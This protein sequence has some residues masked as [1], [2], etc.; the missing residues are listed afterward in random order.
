MTKIALG[1]FQDLMRALR[2]PDAIPKWKNM[3]RAEDRQDPSPKMGKADY[4]T[5]IRRIVWTKGS[6]NALAA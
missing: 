2:G 4:P 1:E 3:S 6:P 5:T